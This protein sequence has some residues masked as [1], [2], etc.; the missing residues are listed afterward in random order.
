MCK[1]CSVQYFG[2]FSHKDRKLTGHVDEREEE[3]QKWLKLESNPGH[4]GIPTSSQVLIVYSTYSTQARIDWLLRHTRLSLQMIKLV[5][6]AQNACLSNNVCKCRHTTKARCGTCI[7]YSLIPRL[8]LMSSVIF[9]SM[10]PFDTPA[11][12][13]L[14]SVSA[15]LI[16]WLCS[17]LLDVLP[18]R[19]LQTVPNKTT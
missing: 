10:E 8:S 13:R 6:A 9:I 5:A 7:C 3:K 1:Y 12:A 18:V 2:P 4:R 19:L 11:D 15:L 16:P 14:P 17:N